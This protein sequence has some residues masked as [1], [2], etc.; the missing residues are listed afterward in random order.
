[1]G[2]SSLVRQ[3]AEAEAKRLRDEEIR[4]ELHEVALYV[5]S[6]PAAQNELE[7]YGDAGIVD[8]PPY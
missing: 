8:W 6:N 7:M 1:M 3:L 4:R 2:V 5:A